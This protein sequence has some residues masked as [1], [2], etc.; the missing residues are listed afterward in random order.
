MAGLVAALLLTACAPP[1]AQPAKP[2]DG[3]GHVG[4]W[5]TLPDAPLEPR[6]A[7]TG[8]WLDGRYVVLGGWSAPPCPA[9]ASCVSPEDPPRRDGAV[10]DPAA[11]TWEK[12]PDAPVPL[13]GA[14]VVLGST[15]YVFTPDLGR[16]DAP[17]TFLAYDSDDRS[18]RTL[19]RPKVNYP[20]L[21]ATDR[22]VLAISGT[23]ETTP[24]RDFTFDPRRELWSTL[25]DDSLGPSFD[26]SALWV[27][28]RLLLMAHDLVPNPGSERPSLLRLAELDRSGR[29]WSAPAETGILG[30]GA[31]W[32][33]GRVVW[34]STDSADG[35]E[36]NNW[37]R[38]YPDGG[39]LDP[40]TGRWS[41]LP[42]PPQAPGY[43]GLFM[44]VDGQ[45]AVGGHLLDPVTRTY[46][47]I[48][49]APGARRTAETVVAGDGAVL[50]WGGYVEDDLENLASG[51][52]LRLR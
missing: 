6:H 20:Y 34:T 1:T 4:R 44:T 51:Q 29:T 17:S 40:A 38:S 23:D 52:L 41:S 39:I 13:T 2:A 26:R 7:A 35:G 25:P 9:N 24:V 3:F 37:G 50:A 10:F 8:V 47:E 45:A 22:A 43:P 31:V 27:D 19:P 21:V 12:L 28:D 15:L 16:P 42:E 11:G 32:A 33:S 46:T 49:A 18:W 30:G 14:A 48:P 5:T 36:V